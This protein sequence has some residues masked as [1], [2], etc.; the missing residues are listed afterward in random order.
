MFEG[1]SWCG[2][3]PFTGNNGTNSGTTA[4]LAYLAK[5][6]LAPVFTG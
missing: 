2:V 3:V 6:T 4:T 1:I 5:D